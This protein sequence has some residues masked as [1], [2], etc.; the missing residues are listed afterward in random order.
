[1]KFQTKAR[2]IDLLGKKQ[3]RDTVSAVAELVKNSYDADSNKTYLFFD[4]KLDS[5]V[6]IDDGVGMSSQDIVDN[7]FTIG[8]YSKKSK[9]SSPKG[10]TY[11]G[12][13]GIGRLASAKLGNN[14]ILVT[15][16]NSE[17]YQL[18]YIRWDIFEN[19]N[20]SL[21]S[22]NI[23]FKFNVSREE[24]IDNLEGYLSEFTKLQI[25]NLTEKEIDLIN[26]ANIESI[27]GF[28]DLIVSY[29][30][31]IDQHGTMI[32]ISDLSE[33]VE[34]LLST[35]Q[36]NKDDDPSFLEN[37]KRL[38]A[39]I[40]TINYT[41]KNNID[42][43]VNDF[44]ELFVDNKKKPYEKFYDDS[45]YEIHDIRIKGKI[46]NGIFIGQISAPKYDSIEMR[47]A[48][49]ELKK[50]IIVDYEAI[51]KWNCGPIEL[52]F[53]HIEGENKNSILS[54]KDIEYIRNKIDMNGGIGIYRDGVRVFPYGESDNDYLDIEKNRSKHAGNYI[55]SAR[56]IFG[57]III[58][59]E[60]NPDLEDK[61]SREGLIEN[62][63]YRYFISVL[64]TLIVKIALD[65]LSDSR[66]NSYAIRKKIVER[67]N[68]LHQ[69]KE[70]EKQVAKEFKK[71][72]SEE[73]SRLKRETKN[74]RSIAN[75]LMID[76]KKKIVEDIELYEENF[77]LSNVN[78]CV[79]LKT[80]IEVSAKVII[81][82]IEKLLITPHE[83]II[84]NID[85]ELLDSVE[86]NN[87]VI[88]DIK[89]ETILFL[90]QYDGTMKKMN[91]DISELIE[92]S[93]RNKTDKEKL[94]SRI[95][96]FQENIKERKKAEE[97]LFKKYVSDNL[98][99]KLSKRISDI[100]SLNYTDYLKIENKLSEIKN[101]ILNNDDNVNDMQDE[102]LK[103]ESRE[104]NKDHLRDIEEF[105][106]KSNTIQ[107]I[108]AII[109]KKNL[110][111]EDFINQL[112]LENKR[113]ND[114]NLL[115]ESLANVGL[116]SEIMSHEF[117]QL[118]VNINDA[119][120][121]MSAHDI[122]NNA[123]YWLKQIQTGLDAIYENQMLMFPLYNAKAQREIFKV[124][125]IILDLCNL[126]KATFD[127]INMEYTIEIDDNDSVI[128]RKSKIYP[129]LTNIISNAVFWTK[130]ESHPQ[131]LFRFENDSL[132][133]EDN[134]T[135]IMS[136]QKEDIFQPFYSLKP[137]GRGLGLTISKNV[138]EKEGHIIEIVEDSEKRLKG[139]CFKIIF[140]QI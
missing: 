126:F 44:V 28:K 37:Q 42:N 65:F 123:R 95:E 2:T 96:A 116:A 69:D 20:R 139:A 24:L 118:F 76:F 109:D 60:K 6:I 135:G 71:K 66:K 54:L 72:L 85:D 53:C 7:W 18:F 22:I 19:I 40:S 16:K 108:I 92:R 115:Y 98:I 127:R 101:A 111:S 21:D 32:L 79:S 8:T 67:N 89:T 100:V 99:N 128:V 36:I 48:N 134:G 23:P 80:Q 59:S 56:N 104:A 47:L 140:K 26:L 64:R 119:I 114:T 43:Q 51:K 34:P 1:M 120:L 103:L 41:Y 131:I 137:N 68:K 125:E 138:L 4:T 102:F 86:I 77:K 15:K 136:R 106:E 112:L 5:L 38:N 63:Y 49:E 61:S 121:Q 74:N 73:L 35:K 31:Y 93:N 30:E 105:N 78:K 133:I 81:H 88:D 25:E 70:R 130:N 9:R 57:K 58:S 14:L 110:N 117:A 97:T 13:K 82:E 11:L 87:K 46:E 129:A 29:L 122:D 94:L 107:T 83:L 12:A 62:E 84:S 10:R 124:K 45:D 91:S 113:L 50:G 17:L 39:F 27:K 55:F 33:D 90:K 132:F 3:I 52:D 75:K